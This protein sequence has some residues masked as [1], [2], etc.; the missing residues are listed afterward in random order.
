MTYSEFTLTTAMKKFGLTLDEQSDIFSPVMERQPSPLLVDILEVNAPLAFAL[1]TEKARSEFVISPLL[2]EIY[3]SRKGKIKLF[4]GNVFNV[5]SSLGLA[6]FFDFLFAH[7]LSQTAIEAPVL[8]VVEA[9]KEN[10][11]GGYGQCVAT[12]VAAQRF[13]SDNNEPIDAIFGAV[14]TGD[15]WKFLSLKGSNIYIDRETYYLDRIERLLGV[16]W[17]VTE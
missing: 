13:N 3:R 4:S 8:A 12:M 10:I 5:D 9:K 6:G 11:P 2:T 1:N 17:R 7:S 14:T 15:V 16:L